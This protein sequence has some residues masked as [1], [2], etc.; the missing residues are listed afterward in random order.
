VIA[1]A[2]LLLAGV[3]A[4]VSALLAY[5]QRRALRKQG[6]AIPS[7]DLPAVSILKPLKGHD[8]G[9]EENLRSFYEQRYPKFEI[10]YSFASRED[11]AYPVARRVADAHPQI[12][13]TFVFEGR[14]CG[15][16][17]KVSRLIPALARA[18]HRHVLISDGDVRI[19][20]DDLAKTAAEFSRPGVGL[21]SNLVCGNGAADLGARLETLHLNGFLM[22]GTALVAGLLRRPCVFGKSILVSRE[23]L[24]WAGGLDGLKDFLAEDFLLGEAVARAGF[25]VVLSARVVRAFSV[26]KS[27]RGFWNRQVRWARMRSRL[28]G[29]GYFCEALASPLP[30]ALAALAA[31]SSRPL[32]V[33]AAAALAVGK[34]FLDVLALRRLG[35]RPCVVDVACLPLKDLLAFGVFWA[36]LASRR[37]N[38]RGRPMTIGRRTLLEYSEKLQ[39]PRRFLTPVRHP[40]LAFRLPSRF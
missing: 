22:A 37:T 24:D 12:E 14:E 36:G 26:R 4:A 9:L 38:W 34:L 18:R 19:G 16:N 21:V 15:S 33:V 6:M 7:D 30:W 3:S 35:C 10:V 1:T 29:A 39:S 20:L 11:S 8:P 5:W 32:V 2:F 28:A 27:V 25:E 31:G 13:S 23:A 40:L 17:P